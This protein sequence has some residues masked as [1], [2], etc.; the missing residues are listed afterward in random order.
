MSG[1]LSVGTLSG[2]IELIDNLSPALAAVGPK[3][4]TLDQQLKAAEQALKDV[5]KAFQS[6]NPAN[7]TFVAEM[8]AAEAK[9]A[10]LKQALGATPHELDA[11]ATGLNAAGAAAA[12]ADAKFAAFAAAT[13]K[14]SMAAV[15]VGATLTASVTAPL[16]GAAYAA[17]QFGGD[18]ETQMTR[19]ITLA[20][21][22]RA[23]VDSLRSQVLAL[24]PATGIGPDEL[25]KGLFVLESYGLK[26]ADAMTVLTT[27]AN[28]SALGMGTTTD[29]ARALTG[30]LFA[31]KNENLSAADAGDILTKAVQVGNMKIDELIPSIAMVNPIA[32]AMGVKFEDVAA[33]LATFSHAGVNTHVAATGLRAI[34]NSLL[35]DSAKT[36]RGFHDLAAATGDNTITMANFRKE[37]ADHGLT[38]AM[39]QLTDSVSKAGDAGVKAMG[40]IIPNIRGFTEALAVY[41]LNGG[42]VVDLLGKLKDAHGTVGTAVT[43]LHKTW[44][45]QWDAMKTQIDVMW[46]TLSDSLLPIFKQVVHVLRDDVIPIVQSAASAF[47]SLPKPVQEG[48]I[49]VA[50]LAAAAGPLLVVA[51]GLAFTFNQV[52]GA[53]VA[54]GVPA[55]AVTGF[56]GS[57]VVPAAAFLAT[58]VALP[59]AVLATSYAITRLVDNLG[60]GWLTNWISST[61]RAAVAAQEAGAAQ[62]A[63]AIA[64]KLTG[65]HAH[66]AADALAITTQFFKDHAAAAL[67]SAGAHDTHAVATRT[68]L[69]K[70]AALTVA[71]R[72]EIDALKAQGETTTEIAK[73]LNLAADVVG[74][75]ETQTRK[76]AAAATTLATAN[77]AAVAQITKLWDE[78]Y[79]FTAK[80]EGNTLGAKLAGLNTWYDAQYAAILK[81]KA[82]ESEKAAWIQALDATLYAKRAAAAEAAAATEAKLNAK[83]A[84]DSAISWA[85]YHK[86]LQNMAGTT[87]D[88]LHNLTE[89]WLAHEIATHQKAKT[90]TADFYAFV[91]AEAKLKDAKIEQDAQQADVTNKQHFVKM[92]ADAH[93]A[94]TNA[95]ADAGNYTAKRLEQL[96]AEDDAAK[97][98]LR[99]WAEL[100]TATQK[101]IKDVHTLSGEYITAAEAKARL[102]AGGSQVVTAMNFDAMLGDTITSYTGNHANTYG[103]GFGAP[104][105]QAYQLATEGYSFEEIVAIIVM[106]AQKAPHPIGPRIPG[107]AG[108]VENFAGGW[109][110]VGERGPETMYVPPHANI[111]PA[112]SGAGGGVTFLPGA[113]VIQGSVLAERD[114]L[115]RLSASL[116]RSI[117]QGQQMGSA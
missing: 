116:M 83:I 80:A 26:G 4:D 103:P 57:V 32:A 73:A 75:Y 61:Q 59:A 114:L 100:S 65:I 110:T 46:I 88:H 50:A 105:S 95:L 11:V 30:V 15:A 43:E 63:I 17:V 36:E 72:A 74:L 37:M 23:E 64:F 90:D 39:L 1:E 66:N 13:S 27:A 91:Y 98:N 82:G 51:G 62:D 92:A 109:A 67:A 104:G 3:I 20:G 70:V 79:Q 5:T 53:L 68:L 117:L 55:A 42:M 85:T 52:V 54:F 69:E 9:V 24:G 102:F 112:G 45:W 47:T 8:G 25:A 12:A 101:A 28:M 18:F 87:R 86:D 49:A 56:F 6:V 34:L 2:R 106:H 44:A 97:E 113:I 76:A 29:V 99:N 33:A 115:T 14:A 7:E 38:A 77:Q 71:Q 78:Y 48:A 81:S 41:K 89:D 111:Y 22:S 60:G 107:F 94:Y 19:V 108:G 58:W 10:A 84:A 93:E 31:Y 35:T 21:A 16:V 40:E 96:K